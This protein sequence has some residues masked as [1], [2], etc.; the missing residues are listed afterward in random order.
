MRKGPRGGE[1]DCDPIMRHTFRAA[2]ED[3]ARQV[4]L[5]IPAGAALSSDG[6]RQGLDADVAAMRAYNAG[7][8]HAAH[9][10]VDASPSAP[11]SD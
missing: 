8:G 7:E 3:F 11:D 5:R 9:A 1:G 4:G 2:S 6:R 10:I